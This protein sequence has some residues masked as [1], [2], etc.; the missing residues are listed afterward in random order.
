MMGVVLII[1]LYGAFWLAMG[2]FLGKIVY[3]G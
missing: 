3:C 2:I 1:L